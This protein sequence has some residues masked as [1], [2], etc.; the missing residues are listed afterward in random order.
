MD[1]FEGVVLD[2]LRAD[3][4]LFVSSQCCIGLPWGGNPSTES[5]LMLLGDG[6]PC[7]EL[8]LKFLLKVSVPR[9]THGHHIRAPLAANGSV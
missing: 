5:A 8:A 4:A 1:P 2:Y 6:M 3:R 7:R 9:A